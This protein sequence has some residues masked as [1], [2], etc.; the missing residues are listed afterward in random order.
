MMIMDRS[1][2][3]QMVTEAL[4]VHRAQGTL[5]SPLALRLVELQAQ[6]ARRSNN[7]NALDR[8]LAERA[9]TERKPSGNGNGNGSSSRKPGAATEK[10][11]GYA[12]KL[13]GMKQSEKLPSL[14]RQAGERVVAGGSID[15][16]TCR[17]LIDALK[18][19]P[20]RPRETKAAAPVAKAKAP[21]AERTVSEPV[22]DG[23]YKLG[24]QFVKVQL[25]QAG[26]RLYAK[27]WD[28]CGWEFAPGVVGKLSLEMALTQAQAAEFGHLYG[29]CCICGRRLT[30]EAS[31]SAG[32][33][34]ICQ[35][36]M[37]W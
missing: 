7:P 17:D 2:E 29:S 13:M 24:E 15:W 11:Q 20:W 28:G 6:Y 23:F 30:D 12:V 18:D 25:N 5:E 9:A 27:V 33:G 32:I 37:G 31:I 14:L 21:A 10:A 22:T 36:K 34:P 26:T 3:Y 1:A 19:L 35:S 4:E 16:M 8:A